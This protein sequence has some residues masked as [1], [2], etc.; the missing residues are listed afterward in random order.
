M[1]TVFRHYNGFF[2]VCIVLYNFLLVPQDSLLHA[3]K[4]EYVEAVE[5]LLEWEERIHQPGQ[6]Y[7]STRT[8]INR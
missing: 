2:G 3:I 4:E 1:L 8:D 5:I 6:P 7:V